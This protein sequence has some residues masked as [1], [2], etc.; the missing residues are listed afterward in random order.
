M[1]EKMTQIFQLLDS[2]EGLAEKL[3]MLEEAEEAQA[4]LSE[5]GLEVS[6]EE[7][8]EFRNAMQAYA[9]KNEGDLTDE[10]LEEVA[11]GF[12]NGWIK[13]AERAFNDGK[14]DGGG[15]WIPDLRLPRI[16]RIPSGW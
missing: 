13:D 1:K 5:R 14:N 3:F 16:P 12:L 10:E 8:T 11:G 2:E 6:I 9:N 15:H 4:M 7:L